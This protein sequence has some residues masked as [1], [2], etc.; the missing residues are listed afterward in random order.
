MIKTC[1]ENLKC[2]CELASFEIRLTSVTVKCEHVT[3]NKTKTNA[4]T[5][6]TRTHGF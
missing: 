4:S 5:T 1:N 6:I 2:S 3:I